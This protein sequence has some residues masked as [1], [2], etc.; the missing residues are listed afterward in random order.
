MIV[1][2]AEIYREALPH[3]TRIELTE[4][5][6]TFHGDVTLPAFD[7]KDWHEIARDERSALDGLRYSYVTLVRAT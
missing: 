1:G 6:G 2:G 7:P 3:A 5:H 4:V